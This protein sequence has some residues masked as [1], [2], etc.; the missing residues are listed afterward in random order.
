VSS[1]R[2]EQLKLVVQTKKNEV[3]LDA[4]EE[5]ESAL[6]G[7]PR[8][9]AAKELRFSGGVDFGNRDK[10]CFVLFSSHGLYYPA[11]S[12]IVILRR[13]AVDL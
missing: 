13:R 1:A 10:R 4:V 5:F 12:D 2:I 11:T 3:W 6:L 7:D 9:H 8:V